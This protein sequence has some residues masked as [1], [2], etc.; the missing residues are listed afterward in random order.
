M[1]ARIAAT[2][3]LA[4][5]LIGY[6]V[7]VRPLEAR[8]AHG[9]ADIASARAAIEDGAALSERIAASQRERLRLRATLARYALTGDSAATL[10]RFLEASS[11]AAIRHGVS[12]RALDAEPAGSSRIAAEH[13]LFDELS[14]RLTLRGS[15]A[16]LLATLRD[17]VT[18]PPANRIALE[19]L[20]PDDRRNGDPALA[21]VVHVV[22]LRL[23]PTGDASPQPH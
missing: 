7:A 16:A 23:P 13:S 19:T 2:L 18:A 17:L 1:N 4:I 20:A 3:A 10:Q 5:V 14:L 21:A 22:L 9:Y 8:I 12:I 11:A 6:A 15:Y